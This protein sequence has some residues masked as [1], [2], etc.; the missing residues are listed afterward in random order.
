[1]IPGL[2]EA[3]AHLD[4]IAA[5]DGPPHQVVKSIPIT[6][7]DGAPLIAHLCRCGYLADDARM[8]RHLDGTDRKERR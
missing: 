2:R 6:T 8:D 5:M 3:I 4:H 1:M 7:H